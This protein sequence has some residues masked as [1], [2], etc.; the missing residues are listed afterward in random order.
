LASAFVV[1]LLGWYFL[2]WPLTEPT[3]YDN[4]VWVLK[5]S[6]RVLFLSHRNIHCCFSFF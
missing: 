2:L 3:L 5:F 6:R 4:N 1:G